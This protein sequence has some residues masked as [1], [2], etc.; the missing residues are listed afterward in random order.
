MEIR[1]DL[2]IPEDSIVIG[3]HGGKE[4]FD[5]NFVKEV[6]KNFLKSDEIFI[7][8]FLILKSL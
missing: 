8:Y 3:R 4:T 5:I 6:I 2:N 1:S 7:F